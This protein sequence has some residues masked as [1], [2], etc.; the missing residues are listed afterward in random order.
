MT[1]KKV[2]IKDIANYLDVSVTAV[3]FALNDKG[4]IS[5]ETRSRIKEVASNMGY[6]PDHLARSLVTGVS[7]TIGVIIPDVSNQFFAETVRYLQ[8]D[9]SIIPLP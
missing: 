3:S 9:S 5:E 1:G 8:T 7:H 6:R 2:T 4:D